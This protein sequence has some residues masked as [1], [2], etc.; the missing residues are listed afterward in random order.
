MIEPSLA[1]RVCAAAVFDVAYAASVGNL[2]NRLWLGKSNTPANERRLVYWLAACSVLMLVAIPLQLLLLA[3]AMTGDLSWTLAWS[4]LPD[5]VTTHSGHT[6]MMSF[7]FVP[8]LLAFS[9]IPSALRFKTGIGIAL[10]LGVTVYRA[11]F[12]HAASD[13]DFTIREF[14]QL[15]HLSSVGIWGGGVVIAGLVV[16]P[17]LAVTAKPEEV[18]QFGRRLSRTVTVA[19]TIVLL[20][21]VFNAWKGLNGSFYQLP[22]TAWGRILTV[23]VCVVLM[24][25]FH[26]A[27]VRRLLQENRGFK[28]DRVG[29]INR[30]LRAEAFLMLFVLVVS[31]YLA[32]LPP[33]M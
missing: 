14:V 11:A 2:L 21:G 30:W 24:A 7:C 3:A 32:N 5:V 23:K 29:L 28:A 19:L 4:A 16:V 26:G 27:R 6:L 25:F 1:M 18:V 31:A 22:H 13:G 12:G 9:F 33:D 17:Q 20:S 10:L 15:L 8:F